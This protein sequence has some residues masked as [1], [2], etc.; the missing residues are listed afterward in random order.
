VLVV[1]D[2]EAVLELTILQLVRRGFRVVAAV[3]VTEALRLITS[4]SFDVLITDLNMPNAGDG[5]TVLT[6]MRHSQPNALILLVSGYPDVERALATIALEPDEIIVKPFAIA[7]LA[8]LL[9]EKMRSRKP[10]PRRA[11]KQRVA[12]ILHRCLPSILADWLSR[13]K[14]SSELNHL[15]LPDNERTGYLSKLIEDVVRRLSESHISLPGDALYSA[16]AV[17]HGKMRRRQGYTSAMLVHESRLLQVTLFE[18][19]QNNLNLLDFS[20]LLPD[21][22][23]IADE[24]DAQLTQAMQSFTE[25]NHGDAAA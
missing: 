8:D 4:E 17:E 19:L 15:N 18:T 25:A 7:T 22:M 3:S 9:S 6:A 2:D 21:V 23:K 20:L 13:A 16:S 5:F 1:D 24:V 11:D 14:L 10:V 12:V